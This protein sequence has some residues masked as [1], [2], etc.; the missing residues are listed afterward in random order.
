MTG[1]GA[2]GADGLSKIKANNGYVIAQ[3]EESCVVFGMPKSTIKLGVVDKVVSLTYI[4]NE[5]VK[6][7]EV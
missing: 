7:M 6:A 4:A 2:D 5:I 3:D 1:M